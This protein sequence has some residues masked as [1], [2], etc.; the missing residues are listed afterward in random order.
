[1][2]KN[3]V[4]N[5]QRIAE[6]LDYEPS[7]GFL[8]WKIGRPK[9]SVGSLAGH[10]TAKGYR[11]IGIDG[12][13]HKAHRICWLLYYGKNPDK[14]IDHIN[15]DTS[16]NRICNLREADDKLNGQN[17]RK[18]HKDSVSGF[19]GVTKDTKPRKKPWKAQI[20]VNK[21]QKYLGNFFT[22]EEA[23]A[24]YVEAKKMLHEGCT[25]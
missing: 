7:T 11:L 1:M 17:Q 10:T 14:H 22:P 3:I 25:I 18:P 4:A 16:D 23:H 13:L 6:L 9:S 2:A 19:L 15:G 12:K 21:K 20:F 24:A 8:R 5:P